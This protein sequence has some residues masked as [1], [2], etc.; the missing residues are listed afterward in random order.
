[1]MSSRCL[2]IRCYYFDRSSSVI[3]LS[4]HVFSPFSDFCMETI[5]HTHTHTHIGSKIRNWNVFCATNYSYDCETHTHNNY[6]V[7]KCLWN[8]IF[9]RIKRS[10]DRNVEH[11]G[12]GNTGGGGGA[13]SRETK[14][15]DTRNENE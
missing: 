1:M 10:K 15:R 14:G 2:L 4:F 13:M 6:V 8:V 5:I 3:L 11:T 12:K 9:A 7:E